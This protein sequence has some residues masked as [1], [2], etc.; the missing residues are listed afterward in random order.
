[1]LKHQQGICVAPLDKGLWL[2]Q[3]E[4]ALIC[5]SQLFGE[6]VLQRRLRKQANIDTTHMIRNLTELQIGAPVVHIEHG[7]GRYLGLEQIRV[8]AQ[9]GEYLKLE[10][11]GQ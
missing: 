9:E 10:Y 7:V 8:G 2:Q 6:Q 5:E 1:M 3:P 4:L 11:A